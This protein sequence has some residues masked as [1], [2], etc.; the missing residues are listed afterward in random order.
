MLALVTRHSGSCKAVSLSWD[1]MRP[2]ALTYALLPVAVFLLGW[3]RT[4]IAIAATL[5][6]LLVW[7]WSSSVRVRRACPLWSPSVELLDAMN[8]ASAPVGKRAL[9]PSRYLEPYCCCW[10]SL[11]LCGCSFPASADSGPK[12]PISRRGMAFFAALCWT[13]ACVLRWRHLVSRLLS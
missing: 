1:L 10:R 9:M 13:L 7:L 3:L 6:L 12:A 5:I 4:S 11:H 8:P 2:L